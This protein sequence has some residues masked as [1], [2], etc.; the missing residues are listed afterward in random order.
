MK[1]IFILLFPALLFCS[2]ESLF[3]DIDYLF[4][5]KVVLKGKVSNAKAS[6][7]Q[8]KA[9]SENEFTLADAAK[10]MVFTAISIKSSK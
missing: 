6:S 5:D 9:P 8:Q 1:K 2:C 7:S 10:V 3:Q 4:M